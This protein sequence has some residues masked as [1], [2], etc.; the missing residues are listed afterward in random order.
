MVDRF[1]SYKFLAVALLLAF[2]W[3]HGRRDFLMFRPGADAAG[4]D[5]ADSWIERIGQ[6]YRLN[7][8]RIQQGRDFRGGCRI[9][10]NAIAV[11]SLDVGSGVF[12]AGGDW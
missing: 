4:Q 2:C 11:H 6:L 12:D 9:G 10:E 7:E 1:A 5:W 8:G 3:A